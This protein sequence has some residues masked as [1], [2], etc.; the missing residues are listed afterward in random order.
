[1]LLFLFELIA[2][3]HQKLPVK[4]CS[5]R[6]QT[7]SWIYYMW[8]ETSISDGNSEIQPEQ[9]KAFLRGL[10][11]L[12]LLVASENIQHYVN[13]SRII[14]FSERVMNGILFECSQDNKPGK[15]H[16]IYNKI[17]FLLPLYSKI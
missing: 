7:H 8:E 14:L 13:E 11:T 6:R 16:A 4:N 17:I 15:A 3:T 1:M 12:L 5:T 10:L 9:K 2:E